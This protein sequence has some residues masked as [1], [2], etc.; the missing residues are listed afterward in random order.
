MPKTSPNHFYERAN[1]AHKGD[2]SKR[3]SLSSLPKQPKP[4]FAISKMKV[5]WPQKHELKMDR[6]R[7]EERNPCAL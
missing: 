5:E 6:K 1:Y 3:T 2:K 4:N 7:T